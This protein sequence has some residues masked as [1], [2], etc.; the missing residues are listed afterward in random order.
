MT[1]RLFTLPQSLRVEMRT[2]RRAGYF[3]MLAGMMAMSLLGFGMLVCLAR[4]LDTAQM[5][6]VNLARRIMQYCLVVALFG[7]DIVACRYAAIHG[8]DPRRRSQV[9]AYCL[10]V[11]GLAS[12]AVCV[13]L[14]WALGRFPLISDPATRELARLAVLI[15]PLMA[16]LD[17]LLGYLQGLKRIR[18]F[19]WSRAA[20]QATL[21]ALVAAGAWKAGVWGWLSARAATEVLAVLLVAGLLGLHRHAWRV[22]D[23][24]LRAEMLRFGLYSTLTN[25]FLSVLL[26]SDVLCLDRFVL[27]PAAI[28][29]YTVP[30]FL[31]EGLLLAPQAMCKTFFPYTAEV[32]HTPRLLWRHMRRM[33]GRTLGLAALICVGAWALAP[34]VPWLF[35]PS[36]GPSVL[37]FR[38]LMLGFAA[39]APAMVLR[40]AILAA[41]MARPFCLAAL[42]AGLL[43]VGLNVLFIGRFGWGVEGAVWA[44]V[45]TH[46]FT[47]LVSLGILAAYRRRH[48]L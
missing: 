18:A 23:K 39:Q 34:L 7:M 21:F 11:I 27:D 31:V 42:A 20:R 36:Y 4:L 3:H 30:Y 19:A 2:V 40:L 41:G 14:F 12:V 5:G 26:L 46:V 33:M 6:Q 15:V 24:P 28:A 16:V 35:G 25:I 45:L 43:N 48:G 8:N 32:S 1:P 17:G 10:R 13:P 29:L 37:Y 38:L 9:L 44:T 22:P 47:A